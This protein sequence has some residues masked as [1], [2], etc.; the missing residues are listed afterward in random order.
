MTHDNPYHMYRKMARIVKRQR[1]IHSTPAR[2]VRDGYGNIGAS[3]P[4]QAVIRR[5]SLLEIGE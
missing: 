5:C 2:W 3:E 1:N 4:E